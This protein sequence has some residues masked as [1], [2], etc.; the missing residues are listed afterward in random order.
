M[1]RFAPGRLTLTE[2]PDADLRRRLAEH[3]LDAVLTK[4]GKKSFRPAGA[5]GMLML[6]TNNPQTIK[7]KL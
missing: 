7:I 3:R 5:A 6:N 4:M 2:A 1:T